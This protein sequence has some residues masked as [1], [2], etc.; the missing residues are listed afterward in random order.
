[1]RVGRSADF[2]KENHRMERG[3]VKRNKSTLCA[4]NCARDQREKG[5]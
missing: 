2:D 1:M 4:E 3:K 5:K